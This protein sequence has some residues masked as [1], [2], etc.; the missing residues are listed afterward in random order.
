MPGKRKCGLTAYQALRLAKFRARSKMRSAFSRMKK[1]GGKAC[2]QKPLA[3]KTHN[4][5]ESLPAVD[6]DVQTVSAG[7]NVY[8]Y[9]IA[10]I[11]EWSNYKQIFKLYR[12]N[13][14]VVTFKKDI[15]GAN[16]YNDNLSA[17]NQ[18]YALQNVELSYL[19]EY[20]DISP[21]ANLEDF[22]K[23][24]KVSQVI[25]TNS[26]PSH[27]MSLTPAVQKQT[28]YQDDLLGTVTK[29]QPVFKEWLDTSFDEL[30]HRGLQVHVT[31]QNLTSK[32]KIRMDAKVYFSCRNQD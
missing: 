17:Q 24:S 28:T 7:G 4:F 3:L 11:P 29:A 19:R 27:T 18:A 32:G 2:I 5:V 25:L 26:R 8:S 30:I 15:T 14:I 21:S 10:E 12:I 16:V 1:G 31:G 20:T 6:I 13:K 23:N 9:H 22:K